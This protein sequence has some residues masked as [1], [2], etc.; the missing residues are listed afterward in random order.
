MKTLLKQVATPLTIFIVLKGLD[1]TVLKALQLYGMNHPVDGINPVSFCNVFFFV[2]LISGITFLVNGRSGLKQEIINLN[3]HERG[4]LVGDAFLSRFLGPVAYYFSLNSLS[5]ITQTLL[6]ALILPVSALL[7]NWIIKESLPK[8][9]LASVVLISSGLLL[10]QMSGMANVENN[11]NLVGLIWSVVGV[12][13]FSG[14][15]LTGRKIAARRLSVGLSIGIGALISALVFGILAIL[16]FGPNHFLLLKLWWVFGVL[17]LYALTL[18]LGSELA[19]RKAYHQSSVATVS[20]LGSLS[21]VVSITS[22][23]VLLKETIHPGTIIG[24][25]LLITGVMLGRKGANGFKT[26]QTNH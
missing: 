24:V 23:A 14:S 3:N 2:Q 25:I 17:L 6:F 12:L 13:A 16:L 9:F 18:S 11:N 21:I 7:A 26:S 20:L 22:A 8:T 15:A 5:V 1:N 4:L 19:L 10:H